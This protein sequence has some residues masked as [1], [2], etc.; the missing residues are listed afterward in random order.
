LPSA[1]LIDQSIAP[2][3]VMMLLLATFAGLALVLAAVGIYGV[4][5]FAVTERTREFGIRQALGAD[6]RTIVSLVLTQGLRTAGAGI[7]LGIVGCLIVTRYLQSM[8]FGVERYDL[9]VVSGVAALLFTV[10]LCACYAPARWATHV[11]PIAALRQ[12]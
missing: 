2:R 12:D 1:R 7:A 5:A 6:R 9:G 11:D 10:A 4:L 3:R 8:L